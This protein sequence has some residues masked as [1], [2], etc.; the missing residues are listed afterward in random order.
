MGVDA[1]GD[2]DD[3]DES[4][5]PPAAIAP[6]VEEYLWE[7]ERLGAPRS[8]R[9]A[10][11]LRALASSLDG[12]PGAP[13]ELADVLPLHWERF[14]SFDR[15]RQDVPPSEET[16]ASDLDV[17]A[18]FATWVR[19]EQGVDWFGYLTPILDRERAMAPASR[20]RMVCS[21]AASGGAAPTRS[22]SRESRFEVAP[23]RSRSNPLE[24]PR[25]AE[26]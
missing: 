15:Y 5:S 3:G 9:D 12:G 23:T 25:C 24:S 16:I 2:E 22:R 20:A 11:F 14:V 1:D 8:E 6:M 18:A 17:A 10:G 7:C 26:A 21:K 4:L 19:D 13:A